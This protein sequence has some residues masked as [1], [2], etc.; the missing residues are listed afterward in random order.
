MS[1]QP[2]DVD[3]TYGNIEKAKELLEYEPRTDFK[4]GIHK[5]V[6]WYLGGK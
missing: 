6:K 3:R 5:F 1:M 4:N 2:G